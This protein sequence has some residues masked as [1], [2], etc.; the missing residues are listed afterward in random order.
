MTR[1]WRDLSPCTRTVI[2]AAGT[3]QLGLFA[4]A[5]IDLTRRTADQV[6]GSKLRWRLLSFVNFFGPLSYF[7]WGRH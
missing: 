5:Q 3:V 1:T 6:R 2:T 7:R 4:A